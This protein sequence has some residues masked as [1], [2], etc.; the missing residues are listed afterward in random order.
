MKKL[1]YIKFFENFQINEETYYSNVSNKT[2]KLLTD[3]VINMKKLPGI[4]FKIIPLILRDIEYDD[5]KKQTYSD[6]SISFLGP[7]RRVVLV[8][9]FGTLIPF[10]TSSGEGGKKSVKVG[11]YYNI[12]GMSGSNDKVTWLN[13]G[14]ERDI[15]NYYNID[16][17]R[18]IANELKNVVN[19]SF[20]GWDEYGNL[21]EVNNYGSNIV[22]GTRAEWTFS[23]NTFSLINRDMKPSPVGQ[24]KIDYD[25]IENFK[26][27]LLNVLPDEHKNLVK[28][29]FEY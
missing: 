28:L 27:K 20:P 9:I 16:L 25:H 11:N 2:K 10:Y 13:K 17:L 14:S 6:V 29:G 15:N 5:F 3:Q 8:D 19:T 22:N 12:W 18:L 1:K 7:E 26:K 23:K 21:L 4:S 24:Y